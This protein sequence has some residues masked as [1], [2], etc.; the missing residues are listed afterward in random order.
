MPRVY[1]SNNDPYDFCRRCFPTEARAEA[2]Y[3]NLGDGPDDRENCFGWNAEHPD[4]ED[5]TYCC[6]DCGRQLKAADN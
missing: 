6:D 4:Y 5:E 1:A 2:E 3:G